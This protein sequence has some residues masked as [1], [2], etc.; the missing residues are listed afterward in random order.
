MTRLLAAFPLLKAMRRL[1]GALLLSLAVTA[2]AQDY[3]SRAVRIIVPYP[4][5]GSVDNIARAVAHADLRDKL[6]GMGL[7]PVASTPD[8][9]SRFWVAE[10]SKWGK[11]VK[12][13]K[14]TAG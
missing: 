1:G 8:D 4:A 12:D 6:N 2:A 9:F 3:P 5:G 14:I 11:V 7:D 13:A 10:S